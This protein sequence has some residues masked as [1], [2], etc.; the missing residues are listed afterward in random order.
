MDGIYYYLEI[1]LSD[2]IYYMGFN[3]VFGFNKFIYFVIIIVVEYFK[4][5]ILEYIIISLSG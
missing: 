4:G 2:V 5:Y 3:I 1:G